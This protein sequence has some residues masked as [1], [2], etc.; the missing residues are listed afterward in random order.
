MEEYGIFRAGSNQ[1]RVVDGKQRIYLDWPYCIPANVGTEMRL[2]TP[3]CVP[4][5]KAIGYGVCVL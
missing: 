4:N 1:M 5:C 2:Y 3:Y